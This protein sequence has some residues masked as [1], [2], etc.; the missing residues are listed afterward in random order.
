MFRG[1]PVQVKGANYPLLKTASEIAGPW[2]VSFDPRWGGPQR[3]T[4]DQLDDWTTRAEPSIRYYSGKATYRTTFDGKRG[5]YLSL[6]RVAAMAQVSLNGR[7]LGVAWCDPWR[8]EIPAGLLRTHGNNLEITV[9]NLWINRLIGDAG[10]P[11]E[12]RLTWTTRNPYHP[13]SPL[14]PSG[15]LGP[16]RIIAESTGPK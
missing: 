6:G 2:E 12:K 16:V 13:D 9:A 10:L 3:V 15:L 11:A 4:F 8:L 5:G 7:D 1:K 14:Q